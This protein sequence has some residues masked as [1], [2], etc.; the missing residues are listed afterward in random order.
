M[1]VIM[2]K[3]Q[4]L[5]ALYI[6]LD[7]APFSKQLQF[8]SDAENTK[9]N[10]LK[11][12]KCPRTKFCAIYHLTLP[13]HVI[14]TRFIIMKSFHGSDMEVQ[15][16]DI[17]FNCWCRWTTINN[18]CNVMTAGK[19]KLPVLFRGNGNRSKLQR[20]SLEIQN[21]LSWLY[22]LWNGRLIIS[23]KSAA[24]LLKGC[25]VLDL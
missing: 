3:E 16:I 24:I 15:S 17:S 21:S 4:C 2:N 5:S 25:M 18:Q 11:A 1:C 19:V 13:R 7:C 10:T 9:E 6:S 8:E 23:K 20:I 14:L 22:C 12:E